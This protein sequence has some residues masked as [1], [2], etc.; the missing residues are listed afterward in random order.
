MHSIYSEGKSVVAERFIR[1]LKNK[2]FK[3]M[4]TIQQ[5]IYFDVLNDFV[6]K[7]NNTV[8]KTIKMKPI[9]VTDDSYAGYNDIANKKILNS[10]L[11]IMLEF[12]GY[13]ANW[14]Q[15]V[16]VIN[17]IKDTVPSTYAISDLNGEKITGSF[18]EKKI[19]KN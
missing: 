8:H 14:S 10:N 17:K 18:Y 12:K 9:E 3:H 19:A 11:V 16:F 6:D 4:T 13:T 15:D 1:T 5:N 2:I 7:C